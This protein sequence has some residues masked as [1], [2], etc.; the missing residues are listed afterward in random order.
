MIRSSSMTRGARRVDG[1]E[2]TGPHPSVC[3]MRTCETRANA[4]QVG[5]SSAGR[6]AL[7]R[8]AYAAAA[9][10]GFDLG[11]AR[12]DEDREV[13][14]RAGRRTA[15]PPAPPPLPPRGRP[16]RR[17]D[18]SDGLVRQHSRRGACAVSGKTTRSRGRAARRPHQAFRAAGVGREHARRADRATAYRTRALPADSVARSATRWRTPAASEGV[19]IPVDHRG[20]LATADPR[21][22][23]R[24]TMRSGSRAEPSRACGPPGAVGGDRGGL[25]LRVSPTGEMVGGSDSV[26]RRALEAFAG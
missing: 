9:C 20:E 2:V 16:A 10:G 23:S 4:L 17:P 7:S 11:G 22:R 21:G 24:T 19:R 3:A 6:D 25:V 8:A 14:G 26:R 13:V 15:H 1:L 18:H 12:R 5:N